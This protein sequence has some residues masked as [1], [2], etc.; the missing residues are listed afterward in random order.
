MIRGALAAAVTPLLDG[1]DSVDVDAIPQLVDFYVSAGLDGLLV[2]GTTGEGVLLSVQERMRVAAAFI[3]AANARLPIVVHCGAQ[4]THDT[5]ALAQ[6][7]AAAGAS[8][9]AVIPP[10]YYPLDAAGLLRHLET[11]AD[12]CAP[13]PFFIYEFAARS[14]YSVPVEVVSELRTRA[15][16]L[17]GLKVSDTPF[18][19][20]QPY[21]L[22]G[23][24]VFIGAESLIHDGLRRGAAGAVSG[25]AAALPELTIRA[26]RSGS[27][28]DSRRAGDVRES[29]QRWP[30]Q[31]ALKQILRRRGL[32]LRGSVRPPLRGLDGEESSQLEQFLD[33]TAR[34]L[35]ASPDQNTAL[36]TTKSDSANRASRSGSRSNVVQR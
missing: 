19:R 36:S 28:E 33:E 29:I 21:L 32:T 31:A 4:S 14:G 7:A 23:L 20:V 24:D 5:A 17:A 16:N 8:A 13:L 12:A 27:E 18:D 30:F 11:A 22:D 1:G 3:E 26:V 15:S 6:D 10:P 2:L 34:E 25:L 9:I 35:L